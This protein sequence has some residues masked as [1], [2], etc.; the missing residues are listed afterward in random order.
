MS[1]QQCKIFKNS[2]K[3][4]GDKAA[5]LLILKGLLFSNQKTIKTKAIP[6][7][8]PNLTKPSIYTRYNFST[9][10]HQIKIC[11]NN[12]LLNQQAPFRRLQPV[13]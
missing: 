6:N 8:T 4:K 13:I 1:A 11:I 12:S 5:K 7:S 2:A 10:K 9:K 3:S